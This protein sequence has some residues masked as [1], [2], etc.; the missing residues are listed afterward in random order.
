MKLTEGRRQGGRGPFG[1]D[2]EGGKRTYSALFTLGFPSV[3]SYCRVL[4]FAFPRETVLLDSFPVLANL[5][6]KLSLGEEGELNP[7]RLPLL[8]RRPL[9]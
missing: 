2:G 6:P 7:H 3:I 5:S 4:E 1:L 8:P 9:P